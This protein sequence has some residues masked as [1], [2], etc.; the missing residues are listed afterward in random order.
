VWEGIVRLLHVWSI[1]IKIDFLR[2]HLIR[3]FGSGISTRRKLVWINI[4][5]GWEALL[6]INSIYC[7]GVWLLKSW[8]GMLRLSLQ[9]SLTLITRTNKTKQ[10]SWTPSIVSTSQIPIKKHSFKEQETALLKYLTFEIKNLP[11]RYLHI[12]LN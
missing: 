12:P 3:L 5:F 1:W 7:Q 10:I 8:L 9:C 2:A 6:L 11:Q 4:Q